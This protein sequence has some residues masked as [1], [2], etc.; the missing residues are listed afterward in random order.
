MNDDGTFS[1]ITC[2]VEVPFNTGDRIFYNP[3]GGALVG[4]ETGSY[5]VEIINSKS[6]KLY[7]S[8]SAID[9]GKNYHS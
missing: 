6:F 2:G 7:G 3:E 9:N 4:L 1:N 5:F 8:P